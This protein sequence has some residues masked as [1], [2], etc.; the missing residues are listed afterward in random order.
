MSA[1]KPMTPPSNRRK[2]LVSASHFDFGRGDRPLPKS[3]LS[4]S[5]QNPPFEIDPKSARFGLSHFDFAQANPPPP[6]GLRNRRPPSLVSSREAN[7]D[8]PFRSLLTALAYVF[9]VFAGP[10]RLGCIA[11]SVS[12][13]KP[14]PKLILTELMTS[15][16]AIDRLAFQP[17]RRLPE[18]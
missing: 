6:L 12:N 2:S 4:A 13:S 9:G 7:P 3:S 10:L 18:S 15:C 1:T 14:K 17:E 8:S 5:P 16:V 11:T